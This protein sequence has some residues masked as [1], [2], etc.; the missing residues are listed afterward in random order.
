LRGS[1]A[2]RVI[3]IVD[4]DLSVRRA[5]RR[6]LRSAGYTVKMYGSAREFLDAEPEGRTT[7]ALV[8]VKMEGMTGFDL[9]EE[10]A[11]RHSAIPLI[12]VTAF[13]DATTRE[14]IRRTGSRCRRRFFRDR[15]S[16]WS[17]ARYLTSPAP[18][19]P[20]RAI[21]YR[22]SPPR[23]WSSSVGAAMNPLAMRISR[24]RCT[25]GEAISCRRWSNC[26]SEQPRASHSLSTIEVAVSSS[27]SEIHA[28]SAVHEIVGWLAHASPAQPVVAHPVLPV[29]AP[30]AIGLDAHRR[31]A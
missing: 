8:D 2:A 25:R 3:D 28:R 30:V 19:R 15:Q 22:D 24:A 1:Y 29:P 16:E 5:V 11:A 12:F 10:L 31:A 21:G 14:R 6:L 7:L 4:D 26:Q 18:P 17:S 27:H 13:D 9:Q 23:S 20:P